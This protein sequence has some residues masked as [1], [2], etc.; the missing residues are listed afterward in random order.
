MSLPHR[1][2]S[3]MEPAIRPVSLLH[4][5]T[6]LDS[7]DLDKRYLKVLAVMEVDAAETAQQEYQAGTLNGACC[8]YNWM[9]NKLNQCKTGTTKK[10]FDLLRNI[11]LCLFLLNQVLMRQPRRKS[12]R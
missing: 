7:R 4:P 10:C 5:L 8:L 12:T 2:T 11:S 3:K 6:Q 1:E 9:L